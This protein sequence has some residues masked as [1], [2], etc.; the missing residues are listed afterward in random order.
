MILSFKAAVEGVAVEAAEP[1]VDC[2]VGK[3]RWKGSP[4]VLKG[5]WK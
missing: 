5:I 3:V 4:R 1:H 2:E